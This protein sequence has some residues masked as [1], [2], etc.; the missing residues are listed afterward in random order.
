MVS[1]TTQDWAAVAE[2][3][4]A[5]EAARRRTKHIEMV[6][7][8]PK[9]SHPLH[10]EVAAELIRVDLEYSWNDGN[11]KSLE[12]YRDVAPEVFKE[13]SLLA[14]AAFEEYRMRR[15]SGEKVAADEYADR[16]SI[17][18]TDWPD[19]EPVSGHHCQDGLE[20]VAPHFPEPGEQFAGFSLIA[21][22][23]RG[24]FATVFLA[25]QADLARRPVA[26]KVTNLRTLE[27]QHLA[28][29]QH[30][31]I[32]PIYSLHEANGLL[33]V[34][35]P[36]LGDRT[37]ADVIAEYAGGKRLPKSGQAF[38]STNAGL[39]DNT[40]VADRSPTT[41]TREFNAGLGESTIEVEKSAARPFVDS[42]VELVAEIAAGLDHAHQRG[43]V[44]RDVKPA[45]IL[46]TSDGHPLLLDFNLSNELVVNG[47]DSLAVGGTLP[48][49]APEHLR[50]VRDG[51]NIDA[52]SD[53]FSLGVIMYELLTGRRPFSIR[54]GAFDVSISEMIADRSAGPPSVRQYNNLV[55]PSIEAIVH[56]C[57]ESKLD[58]RYASARALSED[59]TR[60]LHNLPLIHAPNPSIIERLSKWR[61][62]HPRLMSAA[63]LTAATL[64]LLTFF[65]AMW[66]ARGHYV[67]RLEAKQK[68]QQFSS[69][70]NS[71]RMQI[72]LPD[73]ED[74]LLT[75]GVEKAGTDAWNVRTTRRRRPSSNSR[76]CQF[77][78]G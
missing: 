3:I 46:V 75:R 21:V 2:L 32:V 35:M 30:T 71:A 74:A 43:I 69:E 72:C 13:P 78:I 55:P 15:L 17:P 67:A 66:I 68:Y 42:V 45:N 24:A 10:R 54:E 63:S 38:L 62:R 47:K 26:L 1:P 20:Q 14:G 5:F 77:S 16:F 12:D 18:V 8:I 44:H 28:R 40:V 57:L 22:L 29:L 51:G 58:R 50:A 6:D 36:Y 59:L 61:R 4:D 19:F 70:L 41:T 25:Q 65:A 53:L 34:C 76:L 7:F 37:L 23:G 11:R 52:R 48:Y 64:I 39:S 49:M 73:S 9:P 33:A 60:H 31:N 56:K 27:P